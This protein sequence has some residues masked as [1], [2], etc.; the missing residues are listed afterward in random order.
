VT[1]ESDD[2]PYGP[3]EFLG[4][5]RGS[6]F[7]P[8]DAAGRLVPGRSLDVVFTPPGN[9]ELVRINGLTGRARIDQVEVR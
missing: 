6:L 7:Y 8:R 1:Y 3:E 9:R 4:L 5:A 2:R